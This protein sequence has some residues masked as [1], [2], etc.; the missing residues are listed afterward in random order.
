MD[1]ETYFRSLYERVNEA[2][3][4]PLR[5]VECAGW[6]P[7]QNQCHN[8]VIMWVRYDAE[9]SRVR[10]WLTWGKDEGGKCKLIAH[11]VVKENGE[12]YDITPIY[13]DTPRPSFISHLEADAE[14]DI[15]LPQYNDVTYPFFTY[16]ELQAMGGVEDPS[17]IDESPDA[18]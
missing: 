18:F 14:F 10:G 13:P 15:L 17:P 11:S 9:R 3:S 16:E 12:L 5:A 6:K 8:N 7:E 1:V 2:E 4:V